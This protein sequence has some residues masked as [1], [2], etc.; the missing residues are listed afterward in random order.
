MFP[1]LGDAQLFWRWVQTNADGCWVWSGSTSRE[2]YGRI[3]RKVEGKKKFYA[4]HRVAYFLV[5]GD[6]PEGLEL[7]HTCHNGTGCPGGPD[8]PHR[9]CVNPD[10]LEPVTKLVNIARG[11]LGRGPRSTCRN[12]HDVSVV[13]THGAEAQC[14]QCNRDA[15]AR[16]R[17]SR[18]QLVGV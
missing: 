16:Y 12:G 13:G 14:A 4:A 9:R 6:I 10:H 11:Q 3:T 5:R 2:G 17:Q 7:D 1:G 8:C 15:C 18:R